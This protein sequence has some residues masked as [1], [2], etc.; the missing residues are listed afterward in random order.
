MKLIKL[1]NTK[2]IKEYT[3]AHVPVLCRP[4]FFSRIQI[5]TPNLLFY[6]NILFIIIIIIIII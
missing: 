2:Y 5:T 1:D 3:H 6:Y 4:Y